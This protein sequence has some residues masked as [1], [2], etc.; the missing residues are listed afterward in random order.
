M[1]K[2]NNIIQPTQQIYWQLP[3]LDEDM[4]LVI[5]DLSN[6]VVLEESLDLGDIYEWE[7]QN[8]NGEN[9]PMG[10][11]IFVLKGINHSYSGN[12]TLIP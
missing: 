10:V 8:N 12:I 11:Y 9:L 2:K 6:K 3:E 7:G 5:Y 4:S 1:L